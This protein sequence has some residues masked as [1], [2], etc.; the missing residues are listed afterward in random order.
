MDPAF[1]W[2]WDGEE[3]SEL[4]WEPGLAAHSHGVDV[5]L[6]VVAGNEM[7][8]NLLMHIWSARVILPNTKPLDREGS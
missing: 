4:E 7:H 3:T 5:T 1:L 6:L 8:L 2:F